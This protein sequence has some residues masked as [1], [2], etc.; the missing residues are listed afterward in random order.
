M[1]VRECRRSRFRP[2]SRHPMAC[3]RERRACSMAFVEPFPICS[4]ANFESHCHR[5]FPTRVHGHGADWQ[6]SRPI[7]GRGRAEIP[8]EQTSRGP[9]RCPRS[10]AFPR[11]GQR[12]L[13]VPDRKNSAGFAR[14]SLFGGQC[15]ANLRHTIGCVGSPL[16]AISRP[17]RHAK[18]IG[19]QKS[20]RRSE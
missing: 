8:V 4:R 7:A 13:A 19:R 18:I 10:A 12:R 15:G 20:Y 2:P 14:C 17:P 1:R 9:G 16:P 5:R 3:M 6:G 11:V